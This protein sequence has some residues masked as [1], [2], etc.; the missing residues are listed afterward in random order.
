MDHRPI[1]DVGIIPNGNRIHIATNHC[2]EPH[3]AV[4]AHDDFTD[5]SGIIC[6]VAVLSK[7][8]LDAPYR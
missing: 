2:I 3:A 7:F 1:L 6:Q 4:V 5:D 8:G